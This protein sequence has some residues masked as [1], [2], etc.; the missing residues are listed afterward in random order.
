MEGGG[1][2]VGSRNTLTY[3]T[4][5]SADAHACLLPPSESCVWRA[6]MEN[7]NPD[8]PAWEQ[9]A[10]HLRTERNSM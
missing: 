5:Q 4:G 1:L 7:A 6:I 3:M 8:A 2:P 10:V 9:H